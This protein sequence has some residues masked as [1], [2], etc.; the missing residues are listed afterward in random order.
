MSLTRSIDRE[1]AARKEMRLLACSSR[2]LGT[3]VKMGARTVIVVL[4]NGIDGMFVWD[5]I[6]VEDMLQNLDI[7]N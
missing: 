7:T 2:S 6:G 1:G 5:S 4:T 3:I